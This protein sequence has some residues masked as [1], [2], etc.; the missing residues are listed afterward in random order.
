MAL[1]S[2]FM[3]FDTDIPRL[4]YPYTGVIPNSNW[5]EAY[6]WLLEN[7][8]LSGGSVWIFSHISLDVQRSAFMFCEEVVCSNFILH[9]G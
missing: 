4:P 3:H 2:N 6:S 8:G 7:Y 5:S 9:W 1:D